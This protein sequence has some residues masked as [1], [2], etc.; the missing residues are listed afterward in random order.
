[1]NRKSYCS[2]PASIV[3][4]LILL[5]LAFLTSCSSSTPAPPVVAITASSGGG[6]S[7]VVGMAFTNPLVAKV[8][9]GGTPTS[10]VTVTF[11][12]PAA[13]PSGSFTGAVATA[14]ATTDLNGLATSP[15]FTAGTM[16]GTY[17]V[18]ASGPGSPPN[19]SFNLTNTAGAPTNLATN[20]GTPQNV[21]VSATAA[22]LVANVTDSSG[23]PVHGVSVTFTAP[24]AGAS[25]TFASTTTNTETDTT[26]ASGNAIAADFVAGSAGG[27][28]NVV[29]TSGTLAAVNFV[30]TNIVP[31]AQPLAAGNYVYS[32]SGEDNHPTGGRPY[33][34]AGVFT[35]NSSGAVT[36]GE[37]TFSD[38][39]NRADNIVGRTSSVVA[40]NNGNVLITLDTGDTS[41]GVKG[42]ETFD[43]S[44]ITTSNGLLIEYDAWASGS[45]TLDLQ[46]STAAPSGGYAFFTGG[47][48]AFGRPIVIGG[49]VNVDSVGGISGAGSV[50]DQN[51][52]GT[53]SPDQLFAASTVTSPD[54]LGRVVFTL[55]P[56]FQN[57][58]VFWF[59][60]VGYIVDA[61]NIKWVEDGVDDNLEG[62]TGGVAVG[63]NG[64]NGTYNMSSLSGGSGVFGA[65]GQDGNG[66]LQMAGLLTFNADGSVSGNLSY[67]D[68]VALTPQGG[69]TL[70]AGATYTVDASGSG[71]VT[72]ANVSDGVNTFTYQLYLADNGAPV[73]SMDGT[74]QVSGLD[75][76]QTGSGSFTEASFTGNY[77]LNENQHDTFSTFFGFPH[78]GIGS[79]TADGTSAFT[80]SLDQNIDLVPTPGSAGGVTGTFTSDANGVFT[81]TISGIN[82]VSPATVDNFTFYSIGASNGASAGV[83]GIETGTDQLTLAT[84]ALLQ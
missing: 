82:T 43:A 30:L 71:R 50:F 6:Q 55:K 73:I 48:D 29:T 12:V 76:V 34:V 57:S 20:G 40:G 74:D 81:G 37:Q 32:I 1:M 61:N 31:G 53:L 10:G 21:V 39:A 36:G 80:G 19:A 46:T 67:N 2:V 17:N 68:L 27:P 83:I 70:A 65:A 22:S 7:A 64:K 9:T 45:G 41:I 3:P 14:T 69:H 79:I 35:V 18:T 58:R 24:T 52:G 33:F 38:F 11:R 13:E 78:D 25:G 51:D 47:L 56:K 77:V 63:Q 60:M 62:T 66:P 49:V 4:V 44:M 16:A 84:F 8:T 23:N 42:L 75:Y 15:A 26:D 5:T 72:I 28:Y 54:A 59:M